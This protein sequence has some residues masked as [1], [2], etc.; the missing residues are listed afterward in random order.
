MDAGSMFVHH[1]HGAFTSFEGSDRRLMS[2]G[3]GDSSEFRDDGTE[4]PQR[5]LERETRRVLEP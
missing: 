1:P 4:P 3:G 5:I 2:G